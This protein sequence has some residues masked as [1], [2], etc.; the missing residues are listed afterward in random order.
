[1]L[2][3]CHVTLWSKTVFPTAATATSYG[4]STKTVAL[5]GLL[6]ACNS[7]EPEIVTVTKVLLI[8]IV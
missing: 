3:I 6:A 7:N 5:D 8:F 2:E 4:Y 1:L